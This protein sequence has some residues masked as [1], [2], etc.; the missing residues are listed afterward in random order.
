MISYSLKSFPAILLSTISDNQVI[1]NNQKVIFDKTIQK[2]K[3]YKHTCKK[4]KKQMAILI[5]K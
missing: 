1:S 2:K 5:I 3:R 4:E